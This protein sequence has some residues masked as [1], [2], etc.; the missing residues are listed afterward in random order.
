MNRY[1][2]T[3]VSKISTMMVAPAVAPET[4]RHRRIRTPTT[5]P[6]TLAT[7][8]SRSTAS[9][10][11]VAQSTYPKPTW[12]AG[13]LDLSSV[14]QPMAYSKK[15]SARYGMSQSSAAPPELRARSIAGK[16]A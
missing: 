14:S 2:A 4:P 9:R 7:G 16:S 5:L 15:N 13:S 10:T 8:N 12:H 6:P 3:N 11:V 1:I